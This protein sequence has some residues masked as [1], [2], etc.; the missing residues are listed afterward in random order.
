MRRADGLHK[1]VR[2]A[3][4]RRA[5]MM[6]VMVAVVECH[7]MRNVDRNPLRFK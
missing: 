4:A 3:P 2:V 5:E 6:H 1:H 7:R